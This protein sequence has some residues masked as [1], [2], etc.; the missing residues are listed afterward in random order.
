MPG[1]RSVTKTWLPNTN[2]DNPRNWDLQRVPC[3]ADRVTFPGYLQTA[4]RFRDGSTIMRELV[5]PSDGEIILPTTGSLEVTGKLKSE[6]CAGEGERA[7]DHRESSNYSSKS[8]PD[9]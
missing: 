3:K 5:L 9:P 6:D 1:V 4:V 8:V 7:N 2:Y